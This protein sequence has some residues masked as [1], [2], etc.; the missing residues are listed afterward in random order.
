[1]ADRT[2]IKIPK[3]ALA[4][5]TV[6]GVLANMALATRLQVEQAVRKTEVLEIPVAAEAVA[7][8]SKRERVRLLARMT[9][10]EPAEKAATV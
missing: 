3:L 5:E 6:A 4:G 1:M 9:L 2:Q 8:L 7:D 10:T